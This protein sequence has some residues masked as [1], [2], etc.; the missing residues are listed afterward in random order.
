MVPNPSYPIH[1]YGPVIAGADIRQVQMTPDVDFFAELEHTIRMSLPKPKMLI[2][3]F[4]SNPTAQ[5]VELP[6]FEK[7]IASLGPFLEKLTA[8]GFPPDSFDTVLCTHLHVDHVG[9][10]TRLE[11]G[12]W[13]PTFPKARYLFGAK[14]WAHWANEPQVYGDVV[15]DSIRP[16]IDGRR[17]QPRIRPAPTHHQHLTTTLP[18]V[19]DFLFL[20]GFLEINFAQ[21]LRHGVF[22]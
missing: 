1:I 13:V 20:R 21:C 16:C 6:F 12:R 19:Q 11:N 14:E 5:C 22:C 15:G 8:A 4:P 7:I 10:N 3:N 9:W 2:I 18:P 17:R